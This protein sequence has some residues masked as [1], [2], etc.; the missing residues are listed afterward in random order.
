MTR[1][2]AIT[3]NPRQSENEGKLMNSYLGVIPLIILKLPGVL[4]PVRSEPLCGKERGRFAVTCLK[5]LGL[6]ADT[7]NIWMNRWEGFT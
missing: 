2:V 6:F 7:I 3:G 5:D 1:L 4:L